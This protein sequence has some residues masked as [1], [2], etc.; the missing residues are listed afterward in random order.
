MNEISISDD[1]DNPLPFNEA[2]YIRAKKTFPKENTP[3]NIARALEKKLAVPPEIIDTLPTKKASVTSL[4]AFSI[5]AQ[6]SELAIFGVSKYFSAEPPTPNASTL[7]TR[8]IPSSAQLKKIEQEIGQAWFDGMLSIIDP[9]VPDG[10]RFPLWAVSFWKLLLDI[11]DGQK[12]WKRSLAW[13]NSEMEQR[14]KKGDYDTVMMLEEVKEQLDELPWNDSMDFERRWSRTLSLSHFLGPERLTDSHLNMMVAIIAEKVSPEA[15]VLIAP[16]AFTYDIITIDRKLKLPSKRWNRT[17]LTQY[18]RRI[19]QDGIKELHF[20]LHVDGNHW[21]V[22]KV[23]FI[24][25][26]VSYG[27]SLKGSR[28]FNNSIP[29]TFDRLLCKWLKYAFNRS[30]KSIGTCLPCATQVDSYSCGILAVNSIAHSTTGTPLWEA[31]TATRH[32][33]E[34]FNQFSSRLV[35]KSSDACADSIDSLDAGPAD[36][37]EVPSGATALAIEDHNFPKLNRMSISNLLCPAPDN[38]PDAGSGTN[39]DAPAPPPAFAIPTYRSP[40]PKAHMSDTEDEDDY[41]SSSDDDSGCED[42]DLG[43]LLE[44]PLT[45]PVPV[46]KKRGGRSV[47]YGLERDADESDEERQQKRIRTETGGESRS[48]IAS[49]LNREKIKAGEYTPNQARYNNWKAKILGHDGSAEFGENSSYKKAT[50]KAR[51]L[52]D[53]PAEP[54]KVTKASSILNFFK[55]APPPKKNATKEPKKHVPPPPPST[56]PPLVPCPGLTSLDDNRIPR[57]L[58]RTQAAGGGA[59]ALHIISQEVFGKSFSKLE[60]LDKKEQVLDI[61]YHERTWKNEHQKLR[62]YSTACEKQVVSG[63]P[64]RNR[65]CPGCATVLLSKKFQVALR[66]L[67]GTHFK[68]IPL[69]WQN[70]LIGELFLRCRELAGILDED[71]KR[72]PLLKVARAFLDGRLEDKAVF[73][74]ILIAM[75]TQIDKEERGVGLQ[76]FKYPPAWE[77]MC[78]ILRDISPQSYEALSKHIQMPTGRSLLMKRARQPR[79]PMDINER[80]FEGVVNELKL[81]GYI[82]G[83]VALSCDDTKLLPGYR[84]YYDGEDKTHYLVGGTE[85]RLRVIDPDQVQSVLDDANSEKATKLRL[86]C[87][88]LPLPKVSPIIVAALP[89]SSKLDA[90]QLFGL[91]K[92]LLD[93]LI[94]KGIRVVSYASDG[95]EVERNVQ[96]QLLNLGTPVDRVIKNPHT[97]RP[98][99]RF[100]FTIYRGQAMCIIQDSKHALKTLRNN[101][102]SGA[103]LLTFGNSVAAYRRIREL[104][105]GP[106]SPL[107]KRDVEKLDRQDDNAACRLFSAGVLEY[108]IEH[109]KEEATGEIAYLFIFGELV[110]AFQNRTMAHAERIQLALR[111]RYFLDT[112]TAYL[113]VTEHSKAKHH[114]SRECLDILDILISGLLALAIIH[115]DYVDGL[116]PLVPWLNSTEPCEH[117]FGSARKVI[118]DFTFLDFIY[119]IPKLRIKLREATLYAKTSDGKARASGYNHTYFDHAGVDL[120]ALAEIPS[121]AEMDAI[122]LVASQ[123]ADTIASFVGMNAHLI[124]ILR[125]MPK[126]PSTQATLPPIHR[127]Y[128][129]EPASETSSID[130]EYTA[131]IYSEEGVLAED[132]QHLIAINNSEAP[133]LRD[134]ATDNE[135]ERL[136]V[137]NLALATDDA[138]RV[139]EFSETG[140]ERLEEIVA[141]E[142]E[143]VQNHRKA[144]V[145]RSKASPLANFETSTPL[146]PARIPVG[147]LDPSVLVQTRMRHQTHQAASGLRSQSRS[148]RSVAQSQRTQTKILHQM[149]KIINNDRRAAGEQ[150]VASGVERMLRWREA[151]RGGREGVVEGE[152]APDLAAGS[153]ANADAVAQQTVKAVQKKRKKAFEDALVHPAVCELIEGARVTPFRALLLDDYGIIYTTLGVRLARISVMYSKTAG[154]NGKHAAITESSNI[155]AISYIG[156]RVWEHTSENNF[157]GHPDSTYMT[158]SN[159]YAHLPPFHFLMVLAQTSVVVTAGGDLRLNDEYM[160]HFKNIKSQESQIRASLQIFTGR[161]KKA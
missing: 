63:A 125:A 157:K 152:S 8:R 66:K 61:Q 132:I 29:Q 71:P 52:D 93:G 39:A 121:D 82:G 27:N 83:H 17:I 99:T 140:D 112:W 20:P 134:N 21:I 2:S 77:E 161:K 95:T 96:K 154:K 67:P 97:N 151:A 141:E 45:E 102:F 44:G 41:E 65:P 156:L 49:K 74:S 79:F 48:A 24:K 43:P 108:L 35:E 15:K 1:E 57:Y 137:A 72:S 147:D 131:S 115:R 136:A 19:K 150:G 94:D 116:A 6:S 60:D 85:G 62:V 144:I 33:L 31:K 84:V 81:L 160:A 104:V 133:V 101:L 37:L 4:L 53:P 50:S 111:A 118:K 87:L 25:S 128:V 117:V 34:W 98:D 64:K 12:M 30:F 70:T 109:H 153:A 36:N 90:D 124:F 129:D 73:K 135:M 13:C 127:W 138:M 113:E 122:A 114:L 46:T 11:R 105:D 78:Q 40:V 103:R 26:T 146:C 23:D 38:I 145:A 80:T 155:T 9:R 75:A 54:E 126:P 88:T 100:Q 110:D 148:P 86:W 68:F 42:E 158:Q 10:E 123:E 143:D 14:Q 139:F 149:E 89:I 7:F 106:G 22:G 56:P 119:M 51:A 120:I 58:Q 18:E 107:P 76:N 47:N 159:R 69:R 5:P 3:S 142:Y 59:R 16:L 92:K 130:S 91:L 28:I 32:R 55:P